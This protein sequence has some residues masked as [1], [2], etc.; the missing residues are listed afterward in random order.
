MSFVLI[1]LRHDGPREFR[2]HIVLAF[3]FA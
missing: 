3:F 1:A 2:L